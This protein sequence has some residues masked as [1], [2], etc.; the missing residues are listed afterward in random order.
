MISWS[1]H[2]TGAQD[3]LNRVTRAVYAQ[4]TN[5]GMSERVGKM[6]FPRPGQAGSTSQFYK[7]YS[8]STAEMIDEEAVRIVDEAYQACERLL[9]DKL[10]MVKAL[11]AKLLEKE[12][13]NEDDLVEVMGARPYAKPADYDS[14]VKRFDD[15]RRK[16]TGQGE[17]TDGAARDGATT[18]PIPVGGASDDPDAGKTGKSTRDPRLPSPTDEWIPELA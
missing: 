10:P 17:D 12:V 5:Y 2:S 14:V 7:P 4:V 18:P 1:W 8:E 6:N 15:D 16:R 9:A 11:A 3:D 13:L